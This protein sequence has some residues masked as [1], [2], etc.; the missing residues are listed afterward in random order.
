GI[1]I[2]ALVVA[3]IALALRPLIRQKDRQL[4]LVLA[5][6][7]AIEIVKLAMLPMF[8]GYI[9]DI[10]QFTLWAWVMARLGPAHI[11]DPQY[12]CK[13][14]PA[15]LFALWPAG[16]VAA[17]ISPARA[18]EALRIC[19]ESPPIVADFVLAAAAYA[20]MRRLVSP[21]LAMAGTLLVA[22]N[23]ALVYTSLIW[24]QNDSVLAAAILLSVMMAADS[25]YA[26]AWAMAAL[27]VLLK[28]Q[29]LILL[30]VLGWWTLLEAHPRD[31]LCAAAAA[32][33]VVILTIAPFQLNQPWHLLP[34]LY[35]ESLEWFP[36]ATA[37]AFNLM[38]LLGGLRSY[39]SA[40]VFGI[41]YFALGNI[42]FPAVYPL[43]G[44][45]LWRMRE[46]RSLLLSTFLVYLG[47]FLFETRIHERYLY[48]AVA[49][50]APL[51]F[52]VRASLCLY[53]ALTVTLLFNLVYVKMLLEGQAFIAVNDPMAIVAATINLVAFAIAAVWGLAVAYP[54]T[55]CSPRLPVFARWLLQPPEIAVATGD[56]AT[57][58]TRLKATTSKRRRRSR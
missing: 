15:Y 8:P 36:R 25:R 30:P 37:N 19:A 27:A 54:E 18:G 44:L 51:M 52:D 9:D 48:L 20:A 6:L 23:P 21:G 1:A 50:M 55:A 39:D 31:W 2:L 58:K 4:R 3:A 17:L 14:T 57:S 43:A 49:L 24:G 11:Y 56:R 29:G 46:F 38:F 42:I 26:I 13:Y 32:A 47:M 35:T 53:A 40:K 5:I 10:Q 7:A 45:I 12:V 22:L 28:A 34:D 33:A 16:T 41:S